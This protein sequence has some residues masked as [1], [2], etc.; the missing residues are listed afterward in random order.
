MVCLYA[1]NKEL[2][3]R[4]KVKIFLSKSGIYSIYSDMASIQVI[5]EVFSRGVLVGGIRLST[6]MAYEEGDQAIVALRVVPR[7]RSEFDKWVK[8]LLSVVGDFNKRSFDFGVAGSEMFLASMDERIVRKI[9]RLIQDKSNL[10]I[11]KLFGGA[12]TRS[13]RPQFFDD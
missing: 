9:D 4:I 10:L 12:S 2:P 5:A 3:G 13:Q 6:K 1:C 7:M 8:F 11:V